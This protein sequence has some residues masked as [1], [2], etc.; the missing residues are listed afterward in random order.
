M[1]A[2]SQI[3]G[4]NVSLSISIFLLLFYFLSL[5]FCRPRFINKYISLLLRSRCNSLNSISR[6]D[7]VLEIFQGE[8]KARGWWREKRVE[9]S[10][11]VTTRLNCRLMLVDL[12]RNRFLFH[13]LRR[14][15]AS[16]GGIS[17]T[18]ATRDQETG[19]F[20]FNVD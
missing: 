7:T 13:Q 2:A 1:S 12:T 6:H 14:N 19:T 15:N 16:R 5:S 11:N 20:I 17:W 10:A 18:Y 9:I 3:F 4:L 8:T